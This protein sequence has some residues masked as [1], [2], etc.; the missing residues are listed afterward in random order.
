MRA[1]HE[2]NQSSFRS[3]TFA[4]VAQILRRLRQGGRLA[5]RGVTKHPCGTYRRWN[6]SYD[7]PSAPDCCVFVRFAHGR[8]GKPHLEE[9]LHRRITQPDRPCSFLRK[10]KRA[11]R[12]ET[13]N[14]CKLEHFGGWSLTP[15]VTHRPPETLVASLELRA[16]TPC[17]GTRRGTGPT[18]PSFVCEADPVMEGKSRR[19]PLGARIARVC[20][21]CPG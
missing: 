13:S 7:V 10:D 20:S 9:A 4:P 3:K 14:V 1:C 5:V 12:R 19:S 18:C 8:A 2:T 11:S 21:G 16:R 6:P 15:F 17:S